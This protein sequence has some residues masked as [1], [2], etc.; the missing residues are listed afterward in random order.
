MVNWGVFEGFSGF[1][2][3]FLAEE[4]GRAPVLGSCQKYHLMCFTQKKIILCTTRVSTPKKL[5][6]ISASPN[7]REE[8]PKLRRSTWHLSFLGVPLRNRA[9]GET[10]FLLHVSLQ[11]EIRPL[12]LSFFWVG[13]C[14][15][16]F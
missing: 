5:C 7:R 13:R 8:D 16:V 2:F 12:F 14:Q 11:I 3:K 10:S 1:S 4:L 9:N 15:L 6:L